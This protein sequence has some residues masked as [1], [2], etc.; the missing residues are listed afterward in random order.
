[1]LF[2]EKR[3]YLNLYRSVKPTYSLR[4]GKGQ[5]G[6]D[7][8][9]SFLLPSSSFCLLNIVNSKDSNLPLISLYTL[10]GQSCL[11]QGLHYHL[12]ILLAG[13][14]P[15]L[16]SQLVSESFYP[17]APWASAT[18]K[19]QE[20]IKS[21]CQKCSTL[22]LYFLSSLV[23]AR[24]P[25]AT[26]NSNSPSWSASWQILYIL[27]VSTICH[28]LTPPMLLIGNAAFLLTEDLTLLSP[29]LSTA[30]PAKE[31]L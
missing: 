26:Q 3:D 20:N 1:M 30:S 23:Q 2:L 13:K 14:F 9:P 11:H 7:D 12:Y 25:K 18:W 10:P 21:I 19:S 16:T 4:V 15:A 28:L 27:S 17:T 5:A 31:Y 24:N 22:F 6:T 8:A 29:N